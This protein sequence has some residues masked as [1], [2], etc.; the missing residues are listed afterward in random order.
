[1]SSRIECSVR[2]YQK[3]GREPNYFLHFDMQ[4]SG[5]NEAELRWFFEEAIKQAKEAKYLPE[6]AGP[7]DSLLSP[8]RNES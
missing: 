1:M 5:N 3:E 7:I 2:G 6:E 4:V 8:Q